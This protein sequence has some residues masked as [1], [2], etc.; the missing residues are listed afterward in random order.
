MTRLIQM[1]KLITSNTERIKHHAEEP[2]RCSEYNQDICDQLRLY[3]PVNEPGKSVKL[4]WAEDHVN[5]FDEHKEDKDF[6]F[7]YTDGSLSYNKGTQKTGYGAV[8]YW[9]GAEIEMDNGVMGEFIEVYDVEMKALETASN[10]LHNLLNNDDHATPS[11]IIIS[12]D[13]TGAL[14]RIFQGSPGKAQTSSIAF[15]RIILNLLDR[16]V[17]LPIA[18]TCSPGHFDIAG[19]NRA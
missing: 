2:W 7:I 9:K 13:N 14:Q 18:L 11:R 17:N 4:D 12:S 8:A 19:T 3:L 10:M 6:I 15:R 1:A 5:L 16:H